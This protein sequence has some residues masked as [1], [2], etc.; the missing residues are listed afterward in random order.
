[1]TTMRTRRWTRADGQEM[2]EQRWIERPPPG[3]DKADWPDVGVE[4]VINR[5]IYP[6]HDAE[7]R[8]R[9]A[10]QGVSD[11]KSVKAARKVVPD[12]IIPAVEIAAS[13]V[14]KKVRS[15]H[16]LAVRNGWSVRLTW[17]CGPKLDQYGNVAVPD[18]HTLALRCS[19][20]GRRVVIC[21]D[22]HAERAEWQPKDCYSS[23]RTPASIT[24][25][26]EALKEV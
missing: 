10:A 22:W 9:R 2:V 1:M 18:L 20:P 17:A 12:P 14:P 13:R 16:T 3:I 7:L 21:W 23:P 6:E 19:K 4:K 25:C 24:E 11:A 5:P 26:K 8:A 15:L